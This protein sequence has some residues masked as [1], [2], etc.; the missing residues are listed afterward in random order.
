VGL[1]PYPVE[2]EEAPAYPK[3]WQAAVDAVTKMYSRMWQPGSAE[4]AA[5]GV[6]V[7]DE[8]AAAG[9]VAAGGVAA[10]GLAMADGGSKRWEE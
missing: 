9:G 10:G 4:A 7:V 8:L 6:A 5:G 3:M 1:H 2:R